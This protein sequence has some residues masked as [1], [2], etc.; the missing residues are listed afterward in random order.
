MHYPF[1]KLE[2]FTAFNKYFDKCNFKTEDTKKG[3]H[4]LRNSLATNLLDNDI[5]LTIISSTLGHSNIC[6][7]VSTYLKTD[8][9]SLKKV[10][11]EVDE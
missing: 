11:L 2:Q 5:P 7:T 1:E 9:K 8:I 10:C 6:T 3:I 4:N